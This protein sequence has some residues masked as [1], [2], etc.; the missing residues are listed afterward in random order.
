MYE[1]IS[2][3]VLFIYIV[4]SIYIYD[5]HVNIFEYIEP[6]I[7]RCGRWES[8][9]SWSGGRGACTYPAPSY[10]YMSVYVKDICIY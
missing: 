2:L 10:T 7:R 1:C 9:R 5:L 6:E 8:G 3:S 4:S